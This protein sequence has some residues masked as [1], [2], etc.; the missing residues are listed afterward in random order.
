M[1]MASVLLFLLLIRPYPWREIQ[2]VR[3]S[4]SRR[5]LSVLRVGPEGFQGFY[6]AIKQISGGVGVGTGAALT[7]FLSETLLITVFP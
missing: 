7:K 5:V 2:L 3:R 4:E 6:R 1:I